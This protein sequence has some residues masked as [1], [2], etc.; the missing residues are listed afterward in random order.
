MI[1]NTRYCDICGKNVETLDKHHLIMGQN[2][3]NAEDDKLFIF[4]CRNCHTAIHNSAVSEK[5]SKM[6]GQAIYEQTH[7][8]KSFESKYKINYLP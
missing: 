3:K 7:D 6:L 2:R 1:F 5:L 8:R 4:I